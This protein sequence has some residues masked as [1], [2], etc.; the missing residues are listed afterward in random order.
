MERESRE[1]SEAAAPSRTLR[2][3]FAWVV[4]VVGV[5][6]TLLSI[7]P[8]LFVAFSYLSAFAGAVL[9]VVLVELSVPIFL[10][11]SIANAGGRW[12]LWLLLAGVAV[13]LV[14]LVGPAFGA[15]GVFWLR[16]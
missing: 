16:F 4:G 13:L 7:A 10:A 15:L 14:V 2:L 9:A 3:I 11:L 12:W 6:A 1:S 8:S 5:L